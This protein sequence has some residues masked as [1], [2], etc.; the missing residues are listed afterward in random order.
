[1]GV[2]YYPLHSTELLEVAKPRRGDISDPRAV[3]NDWTDGL[4]DVL[5]NYGQRYDAP[6]ALTETC[7]TG[8]YDR[9]LEW[10]DASVECVQQLRAAGQNIVGYTW[11]PVTDM[12]EWTY[13]YGTEPLENYRLTMGLWDLIPDEI[14][15]LHRVRNPVADRY[16]HHATTAGAKGSLLLTG[17]PA[18]A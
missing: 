9:R 6:V 13:R 15:T 5:T 3:R 17:T 2:N 10:L 14:G 1:M 11:W 8:S 16:L 7:L 12:Y 18:D 4:A